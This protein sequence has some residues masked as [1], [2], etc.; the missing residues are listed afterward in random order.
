MKKINKSLNWSIF[1]SNSYLIII[2]ILTLLHDE[3]T[4][5]L[6]WLR[7]RSATSYILLCVI[8]VY[9]PSLSYDPTQ[10]YQQQNTQSAPKIIL[11]LL[12]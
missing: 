6:E 7:L 2:E 11:P 4:L 3:R 1:L 5:I 9:A 8:Y 12:H 10:F